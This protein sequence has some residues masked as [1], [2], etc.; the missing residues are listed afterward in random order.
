MYIALIPIT[1]P[2]KNKTK[3]AGI[4]I[5]LVIGFIAMLITNGWRLISYPLLLPVGI[6]ALRF[7]KRKAKKKVEEEEEGKDNLFLALVLIFLLSSI[8]ALVIGTHYMNGPAVIYGLIVLIVFWIFVAKYGST[9]GH[10]H[11]YYY[12]ASRVGSGFIMWAMDRATRRRG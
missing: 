1:F 11:G 5:L 3:A 2:V 9:N 7:K 12:A 10:G 8:P 6:L 4:I